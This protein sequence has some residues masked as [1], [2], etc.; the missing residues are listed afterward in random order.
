MR[1]PTCRIFSFKPDVR[2]PLKFPPKNNGHDSRGFQPLWL[3][4]F[5]VSQRNK[6]LC[7]TL[8]L[9]ER[10]TTMSVP[11]MKL[12]PLCQSAQPKC[13]K[14]LCGIVGVQPSDCR[15]LCCNRCY[16][17]I[18]WLRVP[19]F[20]RKKGGNVNGGNIYNNSDV[21]HLHGLHAYVCLWVL[22]HAST[23]ILFQ[24]LH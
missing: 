20:P 24:I 21:C 1:Y 3:L 13:A 6:R 7:A 17:Q 16:V 12:P 15:Q 11:E 22:N 18:H 8:D 9:A 4:H 23:S 2:T 10:G 5:W 19:S 14:W